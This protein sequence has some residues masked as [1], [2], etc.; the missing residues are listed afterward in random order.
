MPDRDQC[1]PPTSPRIPPKTRDEVV[2]QRL[3][4]C[5]A[6]KLREV[7]VILRGIKHSLP[8]LYD[9]ETAEAMGERRAPQSLTYSLIGSVEACLMDD[10]EPAIEALDEAGDITPA[11]LVDEFEEWQAEQAEKEGRP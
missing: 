4:R 10:I 2:A 1:N 11:E 3:I 7:A 8:E 9:G 5:A 6:G